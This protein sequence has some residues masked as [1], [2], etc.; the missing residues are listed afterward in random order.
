VAASRGGKP[1]KA[2]NL[3]SHRGGHAHFVQLLV[4]HAGDD[5]ECEHLQLRKSACGLDCSPKHG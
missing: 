2:Q 4:A 3:F 5:G 1:S